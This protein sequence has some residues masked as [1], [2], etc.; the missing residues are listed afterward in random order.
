MPWLPIYADAIDVET[1]LNILNEDTEVAFII[2][3]GPQRWKAVQQLTTLSDGRYCI[4]THSAGPLPLL[5]PNHEPSELVA[6]PWSGW[7]EIRAGSNPSHPYFGT[8][9]P[10]I[11]WFNVRTVGRAAGA[12]GLSS[13]EWIGNKYRNIG[14]AA[15]DVAEK[16]WQRLGRR[17]KKTGTR[18]PRKGA[19]DGPK[20]EI[21]A[22]PS[23]HAKFLSGTPRDD[24]P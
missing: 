10:K 5:K 24:N 6:D 15:P 3:D 22:C 21:W 16:W 7:T 12:I 17:I 11:F 14:R 19:L 18:I 4:W 9:D 23:A 20:T 2:S 13:F 1:I 8:G